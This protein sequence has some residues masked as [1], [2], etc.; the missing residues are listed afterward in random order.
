MTLTP[1]IT[2]TA[3][4]TPTATTTPTPSE[5]PTATDTPTAS[6][7]ATITPTA[8]ATPTPSDTPTATNTP[9]P[10]ATP[11][12]TPTLGVLGLRHFVI[13]EAKSTFQ[14]KIRDGLTIPVGKFQGQSNGIVEPAFLDLEAGQ[15][16]ANGFVTVNIPRASD[17]I[18]VDS[19]SLAG[20][21]FCIKPLVP[22]TAAGVLGCN[23]GRDVSLSLEQ[24]HHVGEVGV[25]GFTA[26]Q[27]RAL[28]GQVEVPYAVCSAGMVGAPCTVN[29]ECETAVGAGDGTC[30]YVPAR[31]VSGKTGAVCETDDDCTM[32]T[33]LGQCGMPHGGVCNGPLVPALGAGDSGPGELFIAP[34]PNSNTNGMPVELGFES[35]LPCG[36]EGP[37]MRSP[38]ALTTGLSRALVV[39]ANDEAG[40][41]LKFDAQ[42]ENFSCQQWQENTKGRLVIS[43]PA[44]D[45]RLVGD[46]ATIFTFASH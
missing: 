19:K 21:V 12:A 37:G 44:L 9:T 24:N 15:P 22:V 6:P 32:D 36:D 23:G 2:A 3:T 40:R 42:G 43:A 38:F 30:T 8:T 17:Y 14:I 45:Q 5:T 31:C 41:T 20:F 33:T 13:S 26:A 35:E 34:D 39:N 18:F 29:V 28:Q 4:V 7:T 1:T 25:D 11:S 46:V 16:D 27:C 10:S